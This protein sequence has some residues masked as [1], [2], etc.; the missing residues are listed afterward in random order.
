MELRNWQ[1]AGCPKTPFKEKIFWTLCTPDM[2]GVSNH[3]RTQPRGKIGSFS[4]YLFYTKVIHFNLAFEVTHFVILAVSVPYALFNQTQFEH[5][6]RL[7][8]FVTF[9]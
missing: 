8:N 6:L 7:I 5:K 4:L 2:T 1:Q 3:I 9:Y